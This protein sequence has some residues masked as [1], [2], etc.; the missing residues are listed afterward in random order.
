MGPSAIEGADGPIAMNHTPLFRLLYPATALFF[1]LAAAQSTPADGFLHR[2]HTEIVDGAGDPVLLRGISLGDWLFVEDWYA[3]LPG[4]MYSGAEDDPDEGR[5]FVVDLVGESGAREFFKAWRDNY[6]TAADIK[7]IAGWG[8]NSVRVPV[9]YRLFYEMDSGADLDDGF[10]YLDNLIR[11]CSAAH[12]YVIV[13]MHSVPGGKDASKAGNVFVD[14]GHRRILGHIWQRIAARYASEPWVAGYDLINEPVTTPGDGVDLTGAY[15]EIGGAIRQ[16]DLNHILFLEGGFWGDRLDLLGI[17]GHTQ[18]ADE[19]VVLSDHMYNSAI[20]QKPDK[21]GHYNIFD[22]PANRLLARQYDEPL[23]LGEFGDNSNTWIGYWKAFCENRQPGIGNDSDFAPVDWC[24]WLYKADRTYAPEKLSFPASMGPLRAY[25]DGRKSP[26]PLPK[27]TYDE[28][29]SALADLAECVKLPDCHENRDAVDALTRPDFNTRCVPYVK[30]LSIPGH[31]DAVDYDMGPEGLAYH[32][33]VSIKVFGAP[34]TAYNQG[35]VFRND[36]VDI[37]TTS[38]G[39]PGYAVG[40]ID[41]GEWLT[42]TV[43]STPGRYDLRVR[44]SC[45]V[46]GSHLHVLVDGDNASGSV[47][48]PV[49]GDWNKYETITIPGVTVAASGVA[50]VK[51]AF[52]TGGFN[53]DWI[54]FAS[55][56]K[57]K[58]PRPTGSRQARRPTVS[59]RERCDRCPRPKAAVELRVLA[60]RANSILTTRV[61]IVIP[62]LPTPRETLAARE[63]MRYVYL[64]TGRILP[65]VD[66]AKPLAGDAIVIVSKGDDGVDASI[67]HSVDDL[68]PEQYLLRTV[69]GHRVYI[70][71]GD[72]VGT[73]YGAY[74]FAKRLGV[75]FYLYG[76]VVPDR[77]IALELP[78]VDEVSK[79]LFSIR[80]IL[81]FNDFPQ[82]PDWW[83]R[84][85]YLA[86]IDQLPKMGMNFIGLHTYSEGR[87]NA[88]PLVWI[89]EPS[90][91]GDGGGVDFSY[92]AHW[93]TTAEDGWG[94]APAKTGDYAYG[95]SQLFPADDFGA[96]VMDGLAPQ[97]STPDDCNLLFQRTGAIL[98]DAFAE[99]RNVGVKT[100]IGTETPLTIPASLQ[101]R[102]TSQG[103]DAKSRKV[104]TEL[105]EGIFRRIVAIDP[106]DYYWL[107]T[108]ENW[109]WSGNTADQLAS[110]TD[111]IE[112]AADG[113]KAAGNTFK[114][115]TCGWVLG[116]QNDRGALDK[117]LPKDVPMSSLSRNVGSTPI[118]MAYADIAGR[119]KWAIPWLENDAALTFPEPWAGRMRF[120]AVDAHRLGCTGL[121]G[122]H[123]RTKS[124]VFSLS[125][126]AGGAW[127]QS[128]AGDDPHV[129]LDTT[130]G[131][132]ATTTDPIMGTSTPEIYQTVRY[133]TDGYRLNVPN[134]TYTVTLQFVEP[135]YSEAGK[136]VFG[137]KIQGQ[138]VIDSL[139]VFAAAGKDRALDKTFSGIDVANGI[140]KIEFPRHVEFPDIA[141]IVITNGAYTRRIDCGG[142]AIDGY[143]SDQ[144]DAVDRT[145]PVGDL[146]SDYA[147]TN[148]GPEVGTRAGAI[149]ASMDG[150]NMPNPTGWAGPGAIMADRTPW[151]QVKQRYAFVDDFAALRPEIKSP[152]DLDRF[153]FWLNTYENARALAHAACDRGQLDTTME[154]IHASTDDAH[155]RDLAREAVDERVALAHDWEQALWCAE[156]A[157][158][159]PGDLGVITD[160]EQLNR[161]SRHFLDAYDGELSILTGEL[162]PTDAQPSP[163]YHGADRII[164]PTVRSSIHAGESLTLTIILLRSDGNAQAGGTL[165]WRP[166]GQGEYSAI[167]LEHVARGVYRVTLPPPP[168]NAAAI[169][170][171]V[172]SG[173]LVFPSTVPSIDQTVVVDPFASR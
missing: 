63:V 77:R 12:V 119:P 71:G 104:R 60:P 45:T 84:D 72:D 168:G 109:T 131:K 138:T 151:D 163:E 125:A 31:I 165:Y 144:T 65:I 22:V 2:Q 107:W 137:V 16:V 61:V 171:Y 50:T 70:A 51:I 21:D 92:P 140:L 136:R 169:E 148:F 73:L 86:Y 48:L 154:A 7:K 172:K 153:D 164:V 95:A 30:G 8:F 96:G 44:S 64:R 150:T 156:A 89:G 99:A 133:D 170:Y 14:A 1:L 115:A 26:H 122:I 38:D 160:L 126:L 118:D 123:W 159:T 112:A 82:G 27:P 56:A 19:N 29:H 28:A 139:D 33:T 55:T 114:L 162:L 100:C 46:P 102:L 17:D 5:Q 161:I 106:V 15:R 75:R 135:F 24:F 47:D 3:D 66:A 57:A 88:E 40:W 132:I 97:P 42:F 23:W 25:W 59:H 130:G 113:L 85:D 152:G 108:P 68:G 121:I 173:D 127:D 39:A 54:E 98:H 49:T 155:K 158:S 34:V 167:A 91:I 13:D 52:D 147:K 87:P 10:S 128:Y 20:N 146:Y 166:L 36:G 76:D 149:M 81:P 134:G 11:W 62:A 35:G 74:E 41:P 143:E 110:T 53:L 141:G 32:D 105:Y 93:Y 9:D 69:D 83:N 145:M 94:F 43:H 116:P 129:D 142:P 101:D 120:D 58:A 37:T 111:D 80:G 78:Q 18:I 90:D 103:K 79:P 117:T 124:T 6:V 4:T 157:A 67:A